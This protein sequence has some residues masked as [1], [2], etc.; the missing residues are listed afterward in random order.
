M[1][2]GGK[3]TAFKDGVVSIYRDKG[4]KSDFSALKAPKTLGA[5]DFIVKLAYKES[6][7]RTQDVE[8]AEQSGFNLS[9]KVQTRYVP[10]VQPKHKA[11]IGSKL[12]D[13]SY[14]DKSGTEMYLYL[15]YVREVQSD[16]E[17]N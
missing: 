4:A 6:S 12:Y 15:E 13:I 17:G 5:M 3:S 9:L 1:I 16:V 14:L 11:V 8:F 7:K 2:K 10:T